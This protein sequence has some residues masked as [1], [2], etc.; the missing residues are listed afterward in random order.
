M[1]YETAEAN[2]R[3]FAAEVMPRVKELPRYEFEEAAAS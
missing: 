2:M 1:S 3:L